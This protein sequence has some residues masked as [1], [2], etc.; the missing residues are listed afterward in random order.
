MWSVI[1]EHV[2]NTRRGGEF[3]SDRDGHIDEYETRGLKFQSV[4]VRT[5]AGTSDCSTTAT[6][7]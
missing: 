6:T 2:R 4:L 3:C 5:P 1:Q 7:S